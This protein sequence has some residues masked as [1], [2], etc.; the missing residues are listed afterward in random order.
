M[1]IYIDIHTHHPTPAHPSPEGVGIHPWHASTALLDE[2]AMRQTTL[3][4][5]IGLDYA[6]GVSREV[7]EDVFCRQLSLAE[8][9]S[10]PVVLHCVRAFEPVMQCLAR[11]R[12]RAVIFHGFIGSRQQAEQAI[13]R[14]YFLSFGEGAF[15]SPRTLEALRWIPST[16]L[17]LETDEAPTPIET[18]YEQAARERGVSVEEMQQ[19]I[20]ENYNKIFLQH[21]EQ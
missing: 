12:L 5:E 17:F 20:E 2:E 16:H 18:I 19:Q 14:G 1:G 3:I 21:D 9:L 8:R 13:K 15:R 6:C 7:Q 11:Y 4:G 10:K